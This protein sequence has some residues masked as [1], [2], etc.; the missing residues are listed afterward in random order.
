M[1]KFLEDNSHIFKINDKS[2][3][4]IGMVNKIK[5][6]PEHFSQRLKLTS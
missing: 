3:K 4:I 1:K 6:A 5:K 2:K